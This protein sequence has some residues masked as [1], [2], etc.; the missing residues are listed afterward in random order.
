[1][2]GFCEGAARLGGLFLSSHHLPGF[3]APQVFKALKLS[4]GNESWLLDHFG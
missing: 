1:M 2:F 4:Q 3:L